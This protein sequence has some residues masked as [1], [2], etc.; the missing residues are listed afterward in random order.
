M[1]PAVPFPPE[2]PLG[3]L[4]PVS[5][6]RPLA[7]GLP[8]APVSPFTPEIENTICRTLNYSYTHMVWMPK[9]QSRLKCQCKRKELC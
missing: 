2:A 3:P 5:P 6:L 9:K 7:P 4:G 8:L 1:D